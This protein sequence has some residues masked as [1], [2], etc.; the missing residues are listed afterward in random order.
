MRGRVRWVGV[1]VTTSAIVGGAA[2]IVRSPVPSSAA[3]G[4][5]TTTT[6]ARDVVTPEVDYLAAQAQQLG[7]E[8]TAA[9]T[10]LAHLKQQV[11]YEAS[12]SHFRVAVPVVTRVTH[13]PTVT[14]APSRREP[15]TTTTTERAT[16]TPTSTTS[17]TSTTVAPVTHTTT[18]AS[19]ASGS[20]GSDSGQGNDD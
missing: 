7:S 15:A 11:A 10:E 14:S 9:Q 19:G 5:D 12:L 2:A 8:I 18:G 1:V 6:L 16:P 17:T 13:P 3:A 4:R 20:S